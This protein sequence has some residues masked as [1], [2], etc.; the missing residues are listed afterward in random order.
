MPLFTRNSRF[1]AGGRTETS[2]RFVGW[3]ERTIFEKSSTDLEV[4]II[5]KFNRRP[6][7]F[8]EFYLKTDSL[9]WFVL[10]YNNIIDINTEFVTGT[11][12][13]IP[14]MYRI[15]TMFPARAGT[16]SPGA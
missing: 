11:K 5:A 3:W 10:Q 9:W 15:S 6:D 16:F 2:N 8:A 12:I 1:T 13:V 4:T 14:T 7:L